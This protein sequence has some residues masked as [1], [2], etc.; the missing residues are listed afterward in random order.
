MKNELTIAANLCIMPSIIKEYKMT[1]ENITL[2]A[3]AAAFNVHQRTI[4]RALTG[5]HNTYWSEDSAHDIYTVEEIA[6]AYHMKPAE[7]NRVLDGRDKL[8]KPDEAAKE[9]NIAPRTFRL[10]IHRLNAKDAKTRVGRVYNGGIV[11][12]LR[13]RVISFDLA[14]TLD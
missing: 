3:A 6:T 13:S 7:L 5:E 12:Y 9:M 8:L 2:E 4:V 11:R 1:F 14:F 10:R